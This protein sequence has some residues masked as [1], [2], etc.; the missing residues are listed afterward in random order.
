MGIFRGGKKTRVEIRCDHCG[1]TG[2]CFAEV[3]KECAKLYVPEAT[4]CSQ[5]NGRGTVF[6]L[7]EEP[8]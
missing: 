4:K 5:C 7:I 1:A 2:L 3:C 6:R 8:D